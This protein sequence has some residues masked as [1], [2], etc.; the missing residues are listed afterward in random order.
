MWAQYFSKLTTASFWPP[1]P[2]MLVL[3]ENVSSVFPQ[4]QKAQRDFR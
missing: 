4:K 1:P 2:N 3:Q